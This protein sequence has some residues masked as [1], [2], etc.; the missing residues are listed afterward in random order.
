NTRAGFKDEVR[1]YN[2]RFLEGIGVPTIVADIL[3]AKMLKKA[4]HHCNLVAHC[5]AQPA[6]TIAI[7]NPHLDLMT[8]VVGTF[9]VLEA[10]RYWNTA[11][12]NC[13]TIH[14]YGNNINE[15]LVELDTRLALSARDAEM[16]N[17]TYPILN[18]KLSPLHASKR[19]TE[20]YIQTYIDTYNLP[21]ANFRLTGIYGP[22]QFGGEDHGWVANFTIR[23]MF[24]RPIKIFGTDKQVRDILYVKDAAQ[25]F[26]DW[27]TNDCPPGTY[28]IGGG[29][30][31]SKSIGELLGLL[32]D[33][34]GNE[35]EAELLPKRHG[36]LWWFISDYTKA[37]DAFGWTP[38][39]FPYVGVQELIN[40]VEQE[41]RL[42]E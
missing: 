37:K 23:T 22:R 21:A 41:R 27:I 36:D 32:K 9:N 39:V 25:A 29:N 6:M 1:D 18:G 38:V 3:D 8:N 40:W 14:V 16:I 35:S 34:V 30:A 4:M 42:F 10:A 28:N 7:E 17:E 2:L 26:Y 13:S 15:G 11:V 19:A 31:T 33:L 12:I 20:L 5:A 24:N